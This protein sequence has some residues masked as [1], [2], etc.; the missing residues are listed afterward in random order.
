MKR[1]IT[2]L[3]FLLVMAGS[4]FG[5]TDHGYN[6]YGQFLGTSTGIGVG[7]DSRF[8]AGGILGYSLGLAFTDI[9]W[10]RDDGLDGCYASYDAE[11][12]GIS[13]PFEINAI[14]GKRASKFEI[15][16]GMTTIRWERLC[17][18]RYRMW[19]TAMRRR[20]VF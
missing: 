17:P 20:F 7:L 2:L 15:G 11:S 10:S 12:R 6:L 18:I 13:I 16:F 14:W 4:V 3:A 9:S 19:L 8:K 5:Q 1:G